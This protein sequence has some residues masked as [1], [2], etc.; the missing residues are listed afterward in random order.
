MQQVKLPGS[1]KLTSRIGLGCGR[2]VGGAHDQ[3]SQKVLEAALSAGI[4]HFDVAPSYGLGLA[5]RLVGSAV[6]GNPLCTVTTKVGI[7]RPKN[8][9]GLSLARRHLRPL[10]ARLPALKGAMLYLLRKPASSP[11]AM[12]PQTVRNAL[13]ESLEQLGLDYVDTFILHEIYDTSPELVRTFDELVSE[14]MIGAY[15]ASTGKELSQL[16]AFGSIRQFSWNPTNSPGSEFFVQHGVVRRWM[17]A[18]RAALPD[19]ESKCRLND[20]FELDMKDPESHASALLTLALNQCPGS[21]FLLSSNSSQRILRTTKG[22]NWRSVENPSPEF[23]SMSDDLMRN[24]SIY[25][26]SATKS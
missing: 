15:G 2:L 17:A 13:A 1:G 6:S 5:E 18:F 9:E 26:K 4:T 22:I 11:R 12:D 24:I 7:A 23:L 20:L 25:E 16:P 21:I 10:V 3:S 19:V 14:G 8:G